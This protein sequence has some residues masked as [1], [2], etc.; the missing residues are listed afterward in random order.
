MKFLLQTLKTGGVFGDRVHVFLKDDLLGRWRTDDLAEPSEVRRAPGG[1]AR[2]A[3]IMPQEKRFEPE[4]GCLEIKDGI[5]TSPA[6]VPNRFVLHRRDI[7]WSQV[8]R[9]HQ[10]GRLDRVTTV[11]FDLIASLPLGISEGAT[12]Q[13]T[14]PYLVK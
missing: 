7:D 13:Q 3:D 1:L 10:A 12:I 8:T 11:G 2:R 14:W 9:V 5:F 6:Q 4:L